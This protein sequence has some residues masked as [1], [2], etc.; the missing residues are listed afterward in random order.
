MFDLECDYVFQV[1]VV[2]YGLGTLYGSFTAG[3]LYD[4]TS[5]F[6]WLFLY[7]GMYYFLVVIWD[8]FA[9]PNHRMEDVCC[10]SSRSRNFQ[11]I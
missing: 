4:A 10:G 3:L 9:F 5:S 8:E 1:Q 6:M 11:S 2:A 7:I